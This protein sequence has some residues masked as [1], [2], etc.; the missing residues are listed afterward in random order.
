MSICALSRLTQR[1][2]PFLQLQRRLE[3]GSN[4]PVYS[5]LFSLQVIRRHTALLLAHRLELL[6]DRPMLVHSQGLAF[7]VNPT[8]YEVG[9][10]LEVFRT[11]VYDRLPEYAAQQGEIVIDIGT[12][13]G[14]FTLLQAQRGATVYA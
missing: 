3:Q 4:S 11:R 9:P 12:N 13:I 2:R 14:A 6:A 5:A 10:L 8:L 1:L 7:Y